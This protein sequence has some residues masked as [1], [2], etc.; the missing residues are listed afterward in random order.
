MVNFCQIMNLPLEIQFCS[1]RLEF[2]IH[3]NCFRKP[4]FDNER[5]IA[6]LSQD[7]WILNLVNFC[8]IIAKPNFDWLTLV[9]SWFYLLNGVQYPSWNIRTDHLF[10]GQNTK[11]L[12]IRTKYSLTNVQPWQKNGPRSALLLFIRVFQNGQ[13]QRLN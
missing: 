2:V 3:Q 9:R 12:S 4:W 11:Y 10:I 1:D 7:L 13:N 8:H 5:K 6:W